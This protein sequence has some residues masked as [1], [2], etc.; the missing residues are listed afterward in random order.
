MAPNVVLISISSSIGIEWREISIQTWLS[1]AIEGFSTEK[2]NPSHAPPK[3]E[4]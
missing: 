4:G 1:D 3:Q 2:I